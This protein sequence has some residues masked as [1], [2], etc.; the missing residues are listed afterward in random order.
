MDNCNYHKK[1]QGTQIS[2]VFWKHNV[3]SG[4]SVFHVKFVFC[5]ENEKKTKKKIRFEG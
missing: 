5:G 3:K 2:T 4:F 1:A